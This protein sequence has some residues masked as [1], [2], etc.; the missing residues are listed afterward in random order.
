VKAKIIIGRFYLTFLRRSI[1]CRRSKIRCGGLIYLISFILV[2]SMVLT[3]PV[4]AADPNLVGWWQF[5]E[6]SGTTA[7]DSSGNGNDGILNGNPQWVVGFLDGALEFGEAGDEVSVPYSAALNPQDSFTV[8]AW[9]NA[10]SGRSGHGAVISCRDDLPQ[11]GY[12]IYAEPGNTWQFWIGVGTGDVLWNVVQG[13]SIQLDEWVHVAA[14]YSDGTQR[15]YVDGEFVGESS[16]TLNVNT[17]QELLIGAGANETANHNYFFEGAI[18]EV[19]FYNRPLSADEIKELALRPKAYG[20]TPED[21][22][23][24]ISFPG[25]I[26]GKS[27]MW[28]PGDT[29]ASHDVYFGTDYADVEAGTGETFRGNET[30][31]YFLVGYG[32]T[33]NDPCP[34]GFVPGTT[35]Y[36]RIDE[37]EADGVTKYHGD[38]WSFE[39]ADT[40][41][42]D[43]T[44]IDGAKF[45]DTDTDLAWKP[46]LGVIM[47]TLYFGNDY[48]TVND[49]TTGGTDVG[50]GITFDPGPLELDTAYYWRVDTTGVFGKVRSDVWSFT[51]LPD[52]PITDPN[53]IG[54]WKFDAGSGTTAID[55]SGHENHGT[56]N[57]PQWMFGYDGDALE[58][59]GTNDTVSLGTG[60]AL[61]GPTDLSVAAWIKTSSASAGVIIQQRNGG[62]NGEYR[63]MVNGSGQLDLMLYGDGDYQYTFTTTKTVNDGNWHHV[64]A[65]RQGQNG[66]IYVDGRLEASD[67]GTVRSLDSTIQVAIGADVRDSVTYFNGTIDDVR[68]YNKSDLWFNAGH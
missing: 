67:T 8:S 10:V 23:L 13:P 37:I 31:T 9:A 38:V 47:Q 55:W 14:I 59:D 49:A 32:Y 6:G 45:A 20:P 21:G 7:S 34:T 50:G 53:L 1:M 24:L 42:Y 2:L 43:P 11:R 41:A 25:G 28:T 17:A 27:L 51:T 39:I 46:G 35:Y 40:K 58:F 4:N 26:L 18:D 30:A 54:W 65:I 44:P 64:A 36:W 19:R 29:A 12:I 62:F 48:D 5:D 3:G 60:P 52:I 15:F 16:A 22:I 63:F 61:D 33:Q 68:I 66:Y 56:L 57:G